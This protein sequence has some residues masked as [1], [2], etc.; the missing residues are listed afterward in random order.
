V[1]RPPPMSVGRQLF[2]LRQDDRKFRST[3]TCRFDTGSFA[4]AL[5]SLNGGVIRARTT[6]RRLY[7]GRREPGRWRAQRMVR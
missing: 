5:P 2:G 4:Q 1:P 3:L 6:S 7:C